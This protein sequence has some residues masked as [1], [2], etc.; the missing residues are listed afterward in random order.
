MFMSIDDNSHLPYEGQGASLLAMRKLIN[1]TYITLD[2]VIQDPQDWPSLGSFS[3][4]GDQIQTELLLQCDAQL[5][6]RKTYE[7]FAM[8]WPT[9]GG[10]PYGDHINAMP[11]YVFSSQISD[12]QWENT[13]VVDS[14][15][16][17]FVSELKRQDG[18]DIIHYGFGHLAH[19]LMNAGLLDEL[20]LWL[21]PF[22]VGAGGARSLIYADDSQGRFTLAESTTLE[23]GIVILTYT[24]A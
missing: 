16:V 20:R 9:R 19:E 10:T 4:R 18:G 23:S 17:A 14:D 12:P 1:S 6:G 5:M 22:F 2:G 11:K 8:V 24:A 21:H 3:E 15:P 13:T 7:G